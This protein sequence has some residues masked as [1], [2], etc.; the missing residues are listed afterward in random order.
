MINTEQHRA[1]SIKS[2]VTILIGYIGGDAILVTTF[3]FHSVIG[4]A[5]MKL[6]FT[7]FTACEHFPNLGIREIW[8]KVH[9][10]K[11]AQGWLN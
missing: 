10:N 4:C 1:R 5:V 6:N 7:K 11:R 3:A 9:I 8:A 2:K